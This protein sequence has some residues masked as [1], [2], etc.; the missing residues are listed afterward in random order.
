MLTKFMALT[1]IWPK[2]SYLTECYWSKTVLSYICTKPWNQQLGMDENRLTFSDN[3]PWSTT[4]QTASTFCFLKCTTANN[5]I[6][7]FKR[8]KKIQFINDGNGTTAERRGTEQ[9]SFICRY[10][11]HSVQFPVIFPLGHHTVEMPAVPF[12]NSSQTL[13]FA[14]VPLEWC[15]GGYRQAQSFSS[16]GPG[17]W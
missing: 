13:N 11:F 14:V 12:Q 1:Q 15:W 7:S 9:L 16:A 6:F 5:S 2:Q 3:I 8:R 17:G 4:M 10:I